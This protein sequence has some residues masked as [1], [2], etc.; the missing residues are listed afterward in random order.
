MLS[1]GLLR[2]AKGMTYEINPVNKIVVTYDYT[3]GLIKAEGDN[4]DGTLFEPGP[5]GECGENVALNKLIFSNDIF[6][7]LLITKKNDLISFEVPTLQKDAPI[8]DRKVVYLDQDYWAEFQQAYDNPETIGDSWVVEAYARLL[9]YAVEGLIIL[10]LAHTHLVQSSWIS[11]A[12]ERRQLGEFMLA[13]SKGWQMINPVFAQFHDYGVH[14]ELVKTANQISSKPFSLDQFTH[15]FS[16][17]T[18]GVDF[19]HDFQAL[20]IQEQMHAAAAFA[21]KL[22]EGNYDDVI[23]EYETISPSDYIIV[24]RLYADYVLANADDIRS[25]HYYIEPEVDDKAQSHHHIFD[26]IEEL[27]K[28]FKHYFED[29][30]DE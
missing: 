15:D 8:D 14:G 22:L 3:D 10:P 1:F 21:T 23:G 6:K 25:S 30:D 17:R 9:K 13:M 5:L 20:Y 2:Y 26:L 12:K 28:E 7:F 18:G 29:E 19:V 27:D 11:D 16:V 24:A 4:V